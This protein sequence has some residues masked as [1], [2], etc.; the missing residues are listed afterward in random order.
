[1]STLA[2]GQY[3]GN[4]LRDQATS[5]VVLS[6][7]RHS[8]PKRLPAH[9]H[10]LSFL[11]LLL[12]GDY[13][14]EFGRRRLEYRP[15]TVAFH[16]PG[17]HHRDEIGPS[18]G[19][20]FCVQARPALLSMMSE[21]SRALDSTPDLRGGD[22]LWLTLRLHREHSS[23]TS[24]LAVESLALEA[25]AAALHL[26]TIVESCAP[27]WLR[28]VVARLHDEFTCPLTLD[29]LAR[30]AGVH[31][32]H[33]ARTFR[34]FCGQTPGDYQRRLRL[35]F[36]CVQLGKPAC[37]LAALSAEAGFTDQ[38]HLTRAFKQRLGLTPGAFRR[39]YR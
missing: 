2:A 33:L 15:F 38:S 31:P 37:D 23:A 20:F 17:F 6:E 27:F 19:R 24:S 13:V 21:E 14:E 29:E 25:F 3:F 8:E 30:D 9:S 16:P 4:I 26:R 32:V 35:Q 10:E 7:L 39:S 22:V 18:G 1:M 5:A 12:E 36:V 11:C 34:R 28:R